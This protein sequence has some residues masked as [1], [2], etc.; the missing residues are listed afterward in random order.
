MTS[1]TAAPLARVPDRVASV[2]LGSNSFHMLIARL[3][4]G[5]LEIIDRL[6]EPVRLAEGLTPDGA[7]GASVRERALA[8]LE[9]FGQR[10]RTMP[11]G[12]VRVVGTNTL[13]RAHSAGDFL[14][15]AELALG[16][17]I[18]IV[19]G[20]EEARLI[21]LGSAHSIAHH[22]GRRLVVDIGGGSTECI[23]GEGFDVV[24]AHSLSMGCVHF[25]ERYFPEGRVTNK[26][27]KKAVLQAQLELEPV[28]RGLAR[29]GW[30]RAYGASGTIRAV[31]TAAHANGWCDGPLTA[32]GVDRLLKA[33]VA[34]R[35]L[36]AVAIEGLK[37]DRLPVIAGGVAILAALFDSLRIEGME[38]SPGAMREG[39]LYDLVGRIQHEDVRER[40]IRA[41]QRRYHVDVAQASRVAA[42][43]QHLLEQVR[44]AWGLDAEDAPRL[45]GWSAQLHEIGLAVSYSHY[46]RHGGY[47]V[48]HSDMPGFSR[49]EQRVL[50]GILAGH[51]RKVVPEV[52]ALIAPRL[53][54]MAERLTVLLRLAVLVHRSRGG[55]APRGLTLCAGKGRELELAFPRSWWRDHPLARVDLEE[56]ERHLRVLGVQLL[57][58]NA[59]EDPVP[60][61]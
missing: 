11:H 1:E 36:D 43:A 27:M 40:T 8:C 35:E 9:R 57:V 17:P 31:D 60:A 55:M 23:V 10:L 21:Y 59:G 26:A 18:E 5:H 16:H 51:R 29:T 15:A 38:L 58:Q 56:Q 32:A 53:R 24:K 52:F 34:A 47:L 54:P 22:D 50:A 45:L 7:L 12:S 6:R 48:E 20:S 4:G 37:R 25:T 61:E 46:H 2:D 49:D 44:D 13:R 3:V 42:T 41:F 14:A 28:R 19:R 39:V 30:V 33:L